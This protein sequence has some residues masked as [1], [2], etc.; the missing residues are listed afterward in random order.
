V[1]KAAVRGATALAGTSPNPAAAHGA[2]VFVGLAAWMLPAA[3]VAQDTTGPENAVATLQDVA[4]A[5]HNPFTE[6]INLPIEADTG[7]GLGPHHDI[8]EELT[9]QP[10]FPVTLNN[11][12]NLI[13]RPL[14]P[15]T[16]SPVPEKR[17]G[18]GD[19]QPSFFLTPAQVDRWT[20]GVGPAFQLPTATS[21]EL[22]TGKWSAGPTGALIYI[23]GPWFAGVLM[24]QLWSFAGPHRSPVNQTSAEPN[25]SYNFESGWYIQTDPTITY[26]WSAAPRDAWSLPIGLDVGKAVQIGGRSLTFQIGAYDFVKHPAD[27]TQWIIRAQVTFIFPR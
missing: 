15:I 11:D 14:L 9:I 18:L 16:Y 21:N 8:G 25:V 2:A 10:L 12:W 7:F 19:I 22:G 24:S 6:T 26:D 27:A 5:K 20:W 4:Q 13:V 23:E 17:F 3:A 1:S